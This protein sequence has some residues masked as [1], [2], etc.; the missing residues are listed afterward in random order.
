MRFAVTIFLRR[1]RVTLLAMFG[2][3]SSLPAMADSAY[4]NQEPQGQGGYFDPGVRSGSEPQAYQ[5]P[6]ETT[7]VG[8]GQNVAESLTIGNYNRV[9]QIQAGGRDRSNVGIIGGNHDAVNTIQL[10][11]GLTSNVLLINT[12]PGLT[13]NV[14][15]TPGSAPT[16][17]IIARLPDGRW[18][19][20]K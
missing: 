7:K 19:V 4:V 3:C 8:R 16:N 18:L 20:R 5:P 9:A 13:F 1:L 12:P 15:E 17:V 2:I 11:S 14:L 6:P 10:G